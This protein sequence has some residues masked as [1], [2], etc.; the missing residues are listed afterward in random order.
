MN[1]FIPKSLWLKYYLSYFVLPCFNLKS[2][3]RVWRYSWQGILSGQNFIFVDFLLLKVD[4]SDV[5][6]I[7]CLITLAGYFNIQKRHKIDNFCLFSPSSIPIRFRIEWDIFSMSISVYKTNS[8]NV[9]TFHSKKPMK[10]K[11]NCILKKLKHSSFVC[12]RDVHPLVH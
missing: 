1:D 5:I 12:Y 9:V 11:S 7:V 6:S 10:I 4:G 8:W 2:L 3:S